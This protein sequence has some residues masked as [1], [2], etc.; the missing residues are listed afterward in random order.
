MRVT[1]RGDFYLATRIT[2]PRHNLLALRFAAEGE[3]VARP[4]VTDRSPTGDGELDESTLVVA[5]LAGVAAGN[6]ELRTDYVV[7]ALEY[8]RDDTRPESIYTD[9]AIEIVRRIAG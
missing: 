9:L 1:R 7:A 4:L 3:L 6:L 8:R 2:G 5:A